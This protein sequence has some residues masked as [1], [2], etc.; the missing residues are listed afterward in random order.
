MRLLII[1][2][3]LGNERIRQISLSDKASVERGRDAQDSGAVMTGAPVRASFDRH[4]KQNLM[5]HRRAAG[6]ADDDDKGLKK[7]PVALIAATTG[8]T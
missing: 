5:L 2:I 8:R 3:V 1:R 4:S 7:F 6:R